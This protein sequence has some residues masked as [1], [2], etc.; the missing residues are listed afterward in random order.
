M[1][2]HR[3]AQ[4]PS[5]SYV[6]P[7][8]WPKD[9]PKVE[10]V[11]TSSAPLESI[12]YFLGDYCRQYNEDFMLC[13]AQNRDPEHCLKEG[14]RVTRCAQDLIAKLGAKCG[15]QWDAHWKCLENNNQ[16]LRLC[17]KFEHPLNKCVFDQMHLV[18]KIPG[19]P[20]GKPQINELKNPVMGR[21]QK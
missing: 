2:T 1:A 4:N 16:E 7:A 9:V 11:G 21:L 17:R 6:E 15:E 14:R 18:K 20:E 8:P 10:E 19:S 5:F 12:S 3:E 13:K